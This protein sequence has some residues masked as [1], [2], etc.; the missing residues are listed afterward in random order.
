MTVYLTEELKRQYPHIFCVIEGMLSVAG[1]ELEMVRGTRNLWIRDWA[2][3]KTNTHYTKFQYKIKNPNPW[4]QLNVSPCVW[5]DFATAESPIV[6][7]GGNVEQSKEVVLISEI[8]FKHNPR[9]EY[10][11]LVG[12]LESTFDRE[13]V[14]LP[15]EPGDTLGHMDGIARFVDDRTVIVN[16]YHEDMGQEY[17]DYQALVAHRLHLNG[18]F[19]YVL[20]NAYHLMPKINEKQFR[21]RYPDADDFNPGFG[22]YLNFYKVGGLLFMPV[23]NI[24]EDN[25]AYKVMRSAFPNHEIVPVSC[26]DLSMEGGLCNCVTWEWEK[27]CRV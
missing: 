11:K 3:I 17:K 8:I 24:K 18:F 12:A 19:V 2:P 4:P 14:F 10:D 20:P 9:V 15:V 6:L 26:A 27:P 13:V 25:D 16:G 22:Y 7:D 1:V 23:F 5:H 21:Q